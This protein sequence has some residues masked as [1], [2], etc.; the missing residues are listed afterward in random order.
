MSKFC[1][2]CRNGERYESAL[3]PH[4]NSGKEKKSMYRTYCYCAGYNL[5]EFD[6]LCNYHNEFG[7]VIGKYTPNQINEKDNDDPDEYLADDTIK[8]G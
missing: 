3:C 6:C 8:K 4:C 1:V 7:M 2:I 5:L